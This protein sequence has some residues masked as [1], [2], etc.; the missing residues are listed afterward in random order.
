MFL[1]TTSSRS[2]RNFPMSELEWRKQSDLP[3]S[4][5]LH[6]DYGQTWI[7]MKKDELIKFSVFFNLWNKPIRLVIGWLCGRMRI[8]SKFC[9]TFFAFLSIIKHY[10]CSKEICIILLNYA[11]SH[12]GG[13]AGERV[14]FNWRGNFPFPPSPSHVEAG[15]Q[16]PGWAGVRHEET[17]KGVKSIYSLWRRGIGE[18]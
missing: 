6:E 8:N 14:H 12:C 9:A 2:S 16:E 7:H 5:T 1:L 4:V 3:A 15:L 18:R 13:G 17:V 11:T 10:N